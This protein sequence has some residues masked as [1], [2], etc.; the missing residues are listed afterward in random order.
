MLAKAWIQCGYI[1]LESGLHQC[2]R[3]QHLVEWNWLNFDPVSQS[4]YLII[5]HYKLQNV[6]K[7]I[8]SQL[9]NRW[10]FVCPSVHFKYPR[11]CFSC[12]I[13]TFIG[14]RTT[15]MGLQICFIVISQTC[16]GCKMT[17]KLFNN[18]SALCFKIRRT[19]QKTSQKTSQ[20]DQ[21]P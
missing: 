13:M 8:P 20:T 17:Y 4:E 10:K 7:A 2:T 12:L 21:L 16:S 18:K 15:C 5:F 9:V 11:A 3:G 1:S 19:S 6:I 14:F